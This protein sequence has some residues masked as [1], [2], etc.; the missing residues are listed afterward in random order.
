MLVRHAQ[1]VLPGLKVEGATDWMGHRPALPDTIPIISPSARHPGIWYA[2]GHGHLGLTLSATTA[3]LILSR[4]RKGDLADGFTGREVQR[5]G[6][7]GLSEIEPIG[8]A[9]ELLADLG[10]V[11]AQEAE[12]GGRPS[13]KYVVSP[14]AAR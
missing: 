1:R 5:R 2:T 8:A 14:R 3:K 6:W 4:I 10:W 12:T 9:L 11:Q 13:V 7:S